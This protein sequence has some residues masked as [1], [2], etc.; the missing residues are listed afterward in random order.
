VTR[1][2]TSSLAS[3]RRYFNARNEQYM[4][5][6]PAT[7]IGWHGGLVLKNDQRAPAKIVVSHQRDWGVR[8]PIFLP[9]YRASTNDIMGLIPVYLVFGRELCLPCDLLFGAPP[10]KE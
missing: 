5:H 7:A 8:L 2:I 10:D 1:A 4:H 6:L 9:A 3:C